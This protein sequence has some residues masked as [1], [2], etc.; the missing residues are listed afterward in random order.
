[1]DP[2]GIAGGADA[3]VDEAIDAM[4]SVAV[5]SG[6]SVTTG[7]GIKIM[8]AHARRADQRGRER[9]NLSPVRL[10]AVD[11]VLTDFFFGGSLENATKLFVLYA[12]DADNNEITQTFRLLGDSTGPTLSAVTPGDLDVKALNVPLTVS[13]TASKASGLGITSWSIQDTTAGSPGT[14]LSLVAAGNTR[15]HTS[16]WRP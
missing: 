12:R 15:S 4:R 13:F 11:D 7:D 10:L 1:V 9:A 2:A 6:S 14:E 16:T 5:A 3:S 8:G